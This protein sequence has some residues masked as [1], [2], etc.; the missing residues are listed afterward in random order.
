MSDEKKFLGIEILSELPIAISMAVIGDGLAGWLDL[1]QMTTF[2]LVAALFYLA[3]RGFE[4]MVSKWDGKIVGEQSAMKVYDF[5]PQHSPGMNRPNYAN[6]L[7]A[8]EG[9]RSVLIGPSSTFHP[10]EP[11]T[12]Q[13]TSADGSHHWRTQHQYKLG[14]KIISDVPT[15]KVLSRLSS[16]AA[17]INV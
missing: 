13:V 7:C 10:M 9:I 14:R 4:V 16:L 6:R 8:Q 2:S 17:A 12:L 15:L 11:I 1:Q 5:S 3:P